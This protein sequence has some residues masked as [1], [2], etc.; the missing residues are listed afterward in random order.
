VRASR[1]I[2]ILLLL[3]ARGRMTADALAAELE[4][5]VRTIYRD[6]DALHRSGVPLYGESGRD[7]GYRLLD[8]YRTQLTGLTR[9][10]AAA[11]SLAML[12]GPAAELGLGSAAAAAAVKI[13]AALTADLRDRADHVQ[14]R[15]HVDLPDWYADTRD[16]PF[17]AE[18]ADAVWRQRRLRV[19]YRRWKEPREVE[20]TLEP[21]GLVLKGGRWYVVARSNGQLRTYRASHL[22]DVQPVDEQ[23]TRPDDFDLAAHWRTSV[24]DFTTRRHQDQAT[25]RLSPHALERLADLG[26]HAVLDAVAATASEPDGQGWVCAT[27]PIESIDHAHGE[28]L[29]LGAEV[30]VLAPPALRE[31]LTRTAQ[32]LARRYLD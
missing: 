14:R 24:A 16:T 23:F 6:V 9:N 19:R 29:R 17:L 10:E 21:F 11:L 31:R 27:I 1:L 18:V 15:L 28:L 13:R 22:L 4:V 12:P 30:E 26:E 8:G 2:S 20:R 3:Q 7:G 25:V 32:E 5:S